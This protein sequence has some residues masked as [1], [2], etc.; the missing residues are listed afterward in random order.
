MVM[1]LDILYFAWVRERVGKSQ[2]AVDTNAKTAGDLVDELILRDVG[3]AAAFS[4]LSVICVAIDQE[5]G[6]FTTLLKDCRE[7]AFFP[8]MTGG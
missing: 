8:P 6:D 7:V 3:Y 1:K 5:L 4:D 2:E